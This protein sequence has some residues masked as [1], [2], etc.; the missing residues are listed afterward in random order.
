VDAAQLRQLNP[1]LRLSTLKDLPGPYRHAEDLLR[2]EC[3]KPGCPN[4]HPS[5]V[6]ARDDEVIR[7]SATS[8]Y[9]TKRTCSLERRMSVVGGRTDLT[10]NRRHFRV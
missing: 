6:L 7:M 9:G 3:G 10:G 2:Y 8:G 4:D 5:Q 1:E